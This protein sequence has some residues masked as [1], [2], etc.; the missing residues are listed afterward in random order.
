MMKEVVN[1]VQIKGV[2]EL[3]FIIL[4]PVASILSCQ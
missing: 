1:P 3:G 4:L 2:F